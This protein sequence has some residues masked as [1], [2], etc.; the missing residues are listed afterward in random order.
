MTEAL[1][2]AELEQKIDAIGEGIDRLQRN[3]ALLIE[4]LEET[5]YVLREYI[6]DYGPTPDSDE[7]GLLSR[8]DAVLTKARGDHD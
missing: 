2:T 6:A 3:K 8:A 5:L 4:T 7:A 1:T